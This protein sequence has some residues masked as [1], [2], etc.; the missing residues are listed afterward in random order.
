MKRHN[1][2]SIKIDQTLWVK[3]KTPGIFFVRERVIGI[4][5]SSPV[6]VVLKR[7]NEEEAWGLGLMEN[8]MWGFILLHE[9]AHSDGL[10]SEWACNNFAKRKIREYRERKGVRT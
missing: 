7:L 10:G 3:R 4:D 2:R 8:E 9:L 1:V 6:D 5:P